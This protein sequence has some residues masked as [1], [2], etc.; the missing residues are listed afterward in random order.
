MP[1]DLI[2]FVELSPVLVSSP[3]LKDSLI[4]VLALRRK[5]G[6]ATCGRGR[7]NLY[8]PRSPRWSIQVTWNPRDPYPYLAYH[9]LDTLHADKFGITKA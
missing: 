4:V 5:R 2:M 6:V 9:I 1:V 3:G 7:K 8:Q